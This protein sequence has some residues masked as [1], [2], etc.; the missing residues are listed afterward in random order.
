MNVYA[1][2]IE[3]AA[4]PQLVALALSKEPRFSAPRNYKDLEKVAAYVETAA[5]E[6]RAG[7]VADAGLSPRTG[8]VVCFGIYDVGSAH[9]HTCHVGGSS[10]PAVLSVSGHAD[11]RELLECVAA[12]LGESPST[13]IVTFNGV[14]FDV[15][16]L[17]WRMVRHG[18]AV[19]AC[20]RPN[21]GRYA[22]PHHYDLRLILSEGDRRAPGTLES[23]ALAL[24]AS[25]VPH[26]AGMDGSDVQAYVD[27]GRW[28]ELADYCARDVLATAGV[29]AKVSPLL[30]ATA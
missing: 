3:T 28:A 9:D 30:V 25:D 14:A 8:R 10:G 21:F 12:T 4:D 19:P 26:K 17:R 1:I 16:F 24:G 6:W 2:D 27:A 23:W 18:I 7:I 5:A 20:L 15:P 29:W 11:E 13:V 22:G